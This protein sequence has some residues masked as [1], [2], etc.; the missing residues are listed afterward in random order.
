L[1]ARASPVVACADPTTVQILGAVCHWRG[2]L[3]DDGP[4]LVLI[5]GLEVAR[6][7]ARGRYVL[8][9]GLRDALA[10]PSYDVSNVAGNALRT[11][12]DSQHQ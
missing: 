2:P 8:G 11:L 5:E 3:P 7:A 10:S 1:R 9:I 6:V 4:Q 12:M